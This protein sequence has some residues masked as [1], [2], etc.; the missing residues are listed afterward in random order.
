MAKDKSINDVGV[1][2][3]MASGI[4]SGDVSI[5]PQGVIGVGG[6]TR[7]LTVSGLRWQ[8]THQMNAAVTGLALCKWVIW[9]R[10]KGQALPTWALA[11]AGVGD[12]CAT[13]DEN[14]VLVWGAGIVN[15]TDNLKHYEGATKTQRKLAVGDQL[16]FSFICADGTGAGTGTGRIFGV[17]QTFYKS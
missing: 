8:F 6:V 17:V 9:V 1:N 4:V 3:T 12:S 10:R 13:L 7:P 5:L 16:C 14:N 2:Y 11:G 15:E